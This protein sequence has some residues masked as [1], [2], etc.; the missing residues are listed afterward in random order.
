[1]GLS[2]SFECT[3]LGVQRPEHEAVP[4][5][6]CAPG[7]AHMRVSVERDDSGARNPN[8]LHLEGRSVEIVENIDR[9][10]GSDHCYFKVRGDE[11]VRIGGRG[12]PDVTPAAISTDAN[13]GRAVAI[14]G[15]HR[16]ELHSLGTCPM[17]RRYDFPGTA[18]TDRQTDFRKSKEE[19]FLQRSPFHTE[20]QEISNSGN[21]QVSATAFA[22]HAAHAGKPITASI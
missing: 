17:R 3:M 13:G 1:M 6:R 20:P 2:G 21:T 16:C 12:W 19:G 7:K 18:A 14:L 9:W 22:C 5:P 10:P 11:L 15:W 8:C 4:L